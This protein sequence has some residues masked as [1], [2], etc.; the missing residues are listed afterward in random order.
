M[1]SSYFVTR[2]MLIRICIHVSQANGTVLKEDVHVPLDT[3][4]FY[5]Q[6]TKCIHKLY[7]ILKKVRHDHIKISLRYIKNVYQIWLLRYFV[8]TCIYFATDR[9]FFGVVAKMFSSNV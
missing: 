4:R 8:Y 1:F 3:E 6:S 7:T 9:I 2:Y 5:S